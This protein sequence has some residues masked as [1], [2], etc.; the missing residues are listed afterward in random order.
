[1][2]VHNKTKFLNLMLLGNL[3]SL[4]TEIS[5][6]RKIEIKCQ[7]LRM[8]AVRLLSW[9]ALKR[10]CE[11]RGE[12]YH[13]ACLH[14]KM[15]FRSVANSKFLDRCNCHCQFV[16]HLVLSQIWLKCCRY[17]FCAMAT[18]Q[19]LP[20]QGLNKQCTRFMTIYSLSK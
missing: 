16:P 11:G 10:P 5:Y 1:M 20:W 13:V 19:N 8:F 2:G 6:F 15:P 3:L 18:C 14:F 12:D 17:F 4:S 7:C 9:D